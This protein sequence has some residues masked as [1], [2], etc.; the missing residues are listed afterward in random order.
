MEV[1]IISSTNY[2]EQVIE[3][4]YLSCRNTADGL[5]HARDRKQ[6][7]KKRWTTASERRAIR[8]NSIFLSKHFG[9]F[10]HAI[11]TVRVTGISR[12]CAN[13]L[14]RHRIASYSQLSQRSVSHKDMD[15]IIPPTIA[16]DPESLEVFLNMTKRNREA[17]DYFRRRK[18]PKQDARY[19]LPEAMETQIVVTMNFR[20][21]LHF[22]RLR[23]DKSAQWEIR[24]VANKIW[25]RLKK[26]APNVFD[27]NHRDLWE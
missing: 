22:L 21:W 26:K 16:D 5:R 4:A 12:A 11:A 10:E 3:T 27:E 15:V 13:Q 23:T 20:A 25:E 18:I 19:V 2:P 8:I 7:N 14:V 9:V 17:Y 24:N 1:E 6:I